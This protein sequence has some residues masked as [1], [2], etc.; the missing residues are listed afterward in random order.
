MTSMLYH[1]PVRWHR[2]RPTDLAHRFTRRRRVPSTV[3]PRE[4]VVLRATG[5][6]GGEMVLTDFALHLRERD[7]MW[8]RIRW[9]DIESV[10]WDAPRRTA[11]LHLWPEGTTGGSR[12]V[13]L[14]T[15]RRVSD[16][17]AEAVT[18]SQL[19][20]RPVSLAADVTAVITALREPGEATIRWRIA[21]IPPSAAGRRAVE[22]AAQQALTEIRA[23]A[24]C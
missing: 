2:G 15:T 19:L 17:V 20:R 1:H 24:G 18:A 8:R 7:G 13:A 9:I 12:S 14:P 10:G 3:Q 11:V 6:T 23:L 5:S 22:E 16:V 21:F 4:R